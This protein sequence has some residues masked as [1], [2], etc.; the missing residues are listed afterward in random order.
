VDPVAFPLPHPN[1]ASST[2]P[3]QPPSDAPAK[4]I[5][6]GVVKTPPSK[7][8]AA[9]KPA[10]VAS[11]SALPNEARQGSLNHADDK[12]KAAQEKAALRGVY[13]LTQDDIEGLSLD[14]IKELRG[15]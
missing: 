15:Y 8:S 6:S 7:P 5:K 2:Q 1:E 11:T 13:T 12:F 14:Q 3:R 4:R 9:V 10:S